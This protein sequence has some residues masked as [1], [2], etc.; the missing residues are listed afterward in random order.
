ME[1]NT[2]KHSNRVRKCELKFLGSGLRN[3]ADGRTY[4]WYGIIGYQVE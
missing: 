2:H 1:Y 4:R 3:M